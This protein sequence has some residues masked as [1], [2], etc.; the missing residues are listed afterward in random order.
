M[1]PQLADSFGTALV[2][3][4][5]SRTAVCCSVTPL[6]LPSETHAGLPGD[7]GHRPDR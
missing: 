6:A 2:P 3:T 4:A 5:P 7:L 1:V